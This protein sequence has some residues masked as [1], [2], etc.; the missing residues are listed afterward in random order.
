MSL[1]FLSDAM[2]QSFNAQLTQLFNADTE[3]A[4]F[5]I[6][7]FVAIAFAV[8]LFIFRAI[9]EKIY[10]GRSLKEL[11]ALSPYLEEVFFYARNKLVCH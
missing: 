4:Y 9:L 5:G 2:G 3:I 8:A 11:S 10:E 1:W 7:G 6:T